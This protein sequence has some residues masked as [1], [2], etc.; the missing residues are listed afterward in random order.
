MKIPRFSRERKEPEKY[1]ENYLDLKIV[2]VQMD[3]YNYEQWSFAI[4]YFNA[5]WRLYYRFPDCF[6]NAAEGLNAC[7][8]MI[9]TLDLVP[10]GVRND[11]IRCWPDF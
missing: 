11:G 4:F 3:A 7:R 10:E 8:T 5:S 2:G 1:E 9:A 6:S